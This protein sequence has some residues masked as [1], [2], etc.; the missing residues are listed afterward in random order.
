M[1]RILIFLALVGC[2]CTVHSQSLADSLL[3]E[4][5][6]KA[7]YETVLPYEVEANGGSIVVSE[8]KTGVVK[9]LINFNRHG[10]DGWLENTST[11]CFV[12]ALNSP[13]ALFLALL[14]AG[15][16]PQEPFYTTGVLLDERSGILIRDWNWR[17]GGVG[18]TSISQACQRSRVSMIEACEQYFCRSMAT[19]AYHL[20]HTGIDLG[21]R[22]TSLTDYQSFCERYEEI[23]WQPLSLLGLNDKV[24]VLQIHMFTSGLACKGKLL[25]PRLN[26][27]DPS[28]VI[29]NPMANPKHI[30]I[31]RKSMI[32]NVK[33]GLS[34]K[35]KSG[36]EDVKVYGFS[37]VG[38]PD[39][40]YGQTSLFTGFI[41]EYTITVSVNMLA[42][43]ALIR[44]LPQRI[45][46]SIIKFL[47]NRS[48]NV[49][50]IERP[51]T[52]SPH[53][54]EK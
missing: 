11:D 31:V 20:S 46:A 21:D 52:Y 5:S 49:T 13:L 32:E 10:I 36:V 1:K 34:K 2:I 47:T 17:Y 51:E 14:D 39:G 16:D 8:T 41:D 24:K 6:K 19:A 38:D 54:A 37:N 15:A 25:M 4:Y 43:N 42:G 3:V 50:Y 29:Y 12:P 28:I 30:S 23:L 48:D 26:E 9:A 18:N 27:S 7:F 22:D 35:A 33:H 44:I 45:A 40:A 53:R